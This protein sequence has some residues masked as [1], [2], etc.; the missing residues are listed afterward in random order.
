M[1]KNLN[2][3]WRV[4]VRFSRAHGWK[5]RT[6][7]YETR[8]TARAEAAEWRDVYGFGNTRV[9]KYVKAAK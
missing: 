4:Q 1:S 3:Q 7:L 6:G 8:S 9:V 2:T 5:N